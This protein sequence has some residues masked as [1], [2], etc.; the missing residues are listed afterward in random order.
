MNKWRL[1][2]SHIIQKNACNLP[3]RLAGVLFALSQGSPE[4][5]L[6][7]CTHSSAHHEQVRLFLEQTLAV[8]VAFVLSHSTK[9][10][11]TTWNSTVSCWRTHR[12]LR[13]NSIC[14]GP[15]IAVLRPTFYQWLQTCNMHIAKLR[16]LS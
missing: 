15:E 8:A 12:V 7:D 6:R 1:L 2:K 11:A 9:G 4:D 16:Q 13:N 10:S 3:Q 5:M 14:A